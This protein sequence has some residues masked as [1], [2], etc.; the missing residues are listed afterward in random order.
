[1]R[2]H[3][4][5]EQAA[6]L[7]GVGD[8]ERAQSLAHEHAQGV[9]VQPLGQPP[10]EDVDLGAELLGLRAAALADLLVLG[11]RFLQ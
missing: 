9:L 1:V 2:F 11:Q 7:L 5:A 8:A 10:R 4:V 3:E 6:H